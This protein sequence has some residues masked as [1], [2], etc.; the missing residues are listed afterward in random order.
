[1]Q[2][3]ITS[4][5][6]T[7][8]LN[9]H[10]EICWLRGPVVWRFSCRSMLTGPSLLLEAPSIIGEM[11]YLVSAMARC[12]HIHNHQT[13]WAVWLTLHTCDFLSQN[14]LVWWISSLTA[15]GY[16]MPRNR[17]FKYR[18]AHYEAHVRSG[19]LSV[20]EHGG[21]CLGRHPDMCFLPSDTS[22]VSVLYQH[23]HEHKNHCCRNSHLLLWS[24]RSQFCFPWQRGVRITHIS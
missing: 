10:E 19:D 5:I 9:A 15:F 24:L 11:K 1:M 2:L 22:H 23:Q 17:T 8:S 20:P 18:E 12:F 13:V 16:W 6:S 4:P 14:S 3:K 21:C 7:S